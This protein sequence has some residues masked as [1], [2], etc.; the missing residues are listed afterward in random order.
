MIRVDVTSSELVRCNVVMRACA[1]HMSCSSVSVVPLG[2]VMS[3]HWARFTVR[4]CI[5]VCLL[6]FYTA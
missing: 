3:A 6:L 1:A 2:P 4:R 5:C